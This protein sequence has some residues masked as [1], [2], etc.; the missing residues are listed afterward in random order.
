RGDG[1][2]ADPIGIDPTDRC[3][4]VQ[5]ADLNGDGFLDL[6][7]FNSVSGDHSVS[8]LLGN[9]NGTFGPASVHATNMNPQ[10][11]ALADVDG[12]HRPD[13]VVGCYG[14]GNNSPS[15]DVL[16][17]DGSGVFP[18]LATR[19]TQQVQMLGLYAADF[20]GD[21]KIDIVGCGF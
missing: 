8:V 6:V 15:I 13:I 19:F 11:L 5:T 12:A 14:D 4:G 9:G 10:S 3:S 2:F 7:T 21:G 20:D 16:L 17:N 1:T 18:A